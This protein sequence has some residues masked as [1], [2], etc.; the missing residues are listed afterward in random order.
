MGAGG[1]PS[2]RMPF[3]GRERELEAL[4]E[5][6]LSS[7]LVTVKG[8]PGAGKTRLARE[9]LGE[10]APV[11]SLVRLRDRDEVLAVIAETLGATGAPLELAVKRV[12][13]RADHVVLDGADAAAAALR[14]LASEWPEARLVVT[15]RAALGVD[16]EVAL[17]LAPLDPAAGSALLAALVPGVDLGIAEAIASELDGLPR[18]IEQIAS[19]A[20]LLGAAE[21]LARLRARPDRSR[22]PR[23]GA[24]GEPRRARAGGG[25]R[26]RAALCVR[27]R[28][29]GRGISSRSSPSRR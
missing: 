10:D 28:R 18:A 22:A 25:G 19:R 5:A 26:P 27:G 7:R 21:C 11:C 20:R 1:I 24:R 29:P 13:A 12:L 2:W 6:A 9:A 14:E 3:V 8:P 17:D 15:A 23:G 4:R 16:G